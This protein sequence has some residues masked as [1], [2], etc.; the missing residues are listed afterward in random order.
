MTTM[1]EQLDTADP[2]EQLHGRL[3]SAGI[4][5]AHLGADGEARVAGRPHSIER[6]LFG[7]PFLGRL[8]TRRWTEL[9]QARGG[10]VSIWPGLWLMPLPDHS[11]PVRESRLPEQLC[12]AVLVTQALKDCEQLQLICDMQRTDRRELL[13]RAGADD[14]LIRDVDVPRLTKLI[15]WLGQ[16]SAEIDRQA[17][18]L[19]SLSREL[20]DS[21]EELS[22]L[23]WFSAGVQVSQSPKQ[24]LIDACRQLLRV[25]DL[26]WM[27]LL[28][29]DDEP[30]LR[31]LAGQ[32][33]TAGR[34]DCD[35]AQMRDVGLRIMAQLTT[36]IEPIIVA[37]AGTLGIDDLSRIGA[38]V[39]IVPVRRDDKTI[40]ILF[41]CDK[42]DGS[43]ITSVDSKFCNSL[44]ESLAMFLD[45]VMIYE[46]M[47]AMFVGTLHALTK[48]IDAKDSYTHGH[49]E[50]VALMSRMLAESVGLDAQ[51][52]ED[53]SLCGLVHDV[54]KIGVPESVLCKTDT[55][56]HAEFELIKQHPEIGARIIGDINQMQKLVPGVMYHHERWDGKGYPHGLQEKDIP[57]FG[58]LL[59]L[60]DSFDAMCSDRT[61]RGSMTRD[62]ACAEIGRCAGTQFDPDLAR[63]FIDIDFDPIFK[64]MAVHHQQNGRKMGVIGP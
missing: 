36:P 63:I 34:T 50:R 6:F 54:G 49:S 30:R 51:T 3:E 16:D 28:L 39:L 58:R 33:V 9:C 52:I 15:D 45:N 57:L 41:G 56:T 44:A 40:G 12:C 61:Y 14:A 4:T 43:M 48:S 7:S 29:V 5:V 64:L 21:Y 24:L 10:A 18:D 46:D 60:A 23:Y 37:D 25:T 2:G 42:T 47:E 22:L 17:R 13:E 59:C 26:R 32:I 11:R 27:S 62:Q 8:V 38:N 35:D 20:G 53:V 31:Q 1:R 19:E 55:L